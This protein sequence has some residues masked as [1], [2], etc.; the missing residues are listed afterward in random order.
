MNNEQQKKLS[1]WAWKI[2]LLLFIVGILVILYNFLPKSL[3]SWGTSWFAKTNNESC[4]FSSGQT[5]MTIVL[6]P[7]EWSCWIVTPVGSTVHISRDFDSKMCFA[8]GEC[9]KRPNNTF[10]DHG[11]RRGIFQLLN[12]EDKK[13]ITTI[14]YDYD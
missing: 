10:R 8:D 11:I 2:A 13:G 1:R 6:Q 3:P 14:T 4:H 7:N 12:L 9:I 5:E